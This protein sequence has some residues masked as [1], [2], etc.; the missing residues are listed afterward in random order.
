MSEDQLPD[1]PTL[2]GVAELAWN[3]KFFK[4]DILLRVSTSVQF[5]SQYWRFY[6]DDQTQSIIEFDH[7]P[8]YVLNTKITATIIK[9][10][11]IFLAI[12]NIT[13]VDA[14]WIS[15]YTIPKNFMR[16]GFSWQLEN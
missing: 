16:L 8:G 13:Q 11:E 5:W 14:T 3:H 15:P 2:S 12:D 7:Q 4:D 1:R 9:K 6:Y 10:A